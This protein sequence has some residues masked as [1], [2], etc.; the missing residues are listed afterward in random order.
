MIRSVRLVSVVACCALTIPAIAEA[1]RVPTQIGIVGV[2][3]STIA[4]QLQSEGRSCLHNRAVTFTEAGAAGAFQTTRTDRDGAFSLTLAD[5]P[6]GTSSLVVAVAPKG[7]CDADTADIGLDQATLTG[8]S[9]DGA[10][11]GVLSSTVDACEPGRR[12]ELYEISSDPVFVGW[13]L[14]D[15]EGEWTIAQ[16]AGRYEARATPS[17][18]GDGD[19]FT[20]CSPAVSFPWSFGEPSET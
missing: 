9:D 11:R 7:R 14:T 13:N 12:I 15:P 1:K 8:G 6:F 3:G 19:S 17:I 18:V 4:L 2:D 5:V 20:L 10:F 16:A